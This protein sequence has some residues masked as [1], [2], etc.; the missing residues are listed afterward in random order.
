MAKTYCECSS[1]G[2]LIPVDSTECGNCGTK[3][4]ARADPA[5]AV[6][7]VPGESA[8]DAAQVEQAVASPVRSQ[9]PM[10]DNTG[11]DELLLDELRKLRRM[12]ER[13]GRSL[14]RW[15]KVQTIILALS[16][17][18][19]TIIILLAYIAITGPIG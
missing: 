8:V 3:H 7:L 1:C 6:L 5:A 18:F 13:Q 11:V 12:Q 14:L 4:E 15:M 2:Y 16:G 9:P 19:V 10:A 17:L